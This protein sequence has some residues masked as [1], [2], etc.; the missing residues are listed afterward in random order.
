MREKVLSI[1]N[2]S[3]NKKLDPI[4]IISHMKK[5]YTSEDLKKLMECL[6]E[7]VNEGILISSKKN[8]FKLVT[9]EFLRAK[10][11][12]VQSG[13]GW[14]LMEGED[15]IFIDKKNML[16]A[17]TGDL[18]LL[19]TFR[20]KGEL[21]ARV[22]RIL[23]R[24]LPL[25]EV[26]VENSV[27]YLIPLKEYKLNIVLLENKEIPL[28]DGEIIRVKSVK[29]DRYN[30]YVKV[31]KKIGH[32]NSPDIDTLE[33]MEEL[34]VP[35][36][37]SE[38]ALREAQSLPTEVLESDF[39]GRKD[40]TNEMIFTIDGKDTKD[41][42]DAIGL[43]I[44]ENGNYLLNVSIADVTNYVKFGSALFND[45]YEK[46]NSTYMADRVEPMLPVELSNGICSLNEGV[47][48]CAVTTLIEL[49]KTGNVV[50]KEMF[51][52]IIKSKKK[53][54]YDDVNTILDG[55]NV[56]GYEE[57]K[58]TLLK[59]YELSCLVKNKMIERGE[60][61]FSSSEIKLIV[62]ENGKMTDIKKHVQYKGETLIEQFMIL[63]NEA[64]ISLLTDACDFGIFRVH[65]T[66]SPKKIEDFIKF[67]SSLGYQINAKFDYSNM[68]NKNIQ[69][70]LKVIKG[71][72]DEEILS[73]K[74]LRSMQKAIYST[75]NIGHY[76]LGSEKYTH[77]TSPIRRFSDLLL[78]YLIKIALF[79]M[80]M[81]VSLAQIG[82]GLEEACEHISMT[83]RRSDDAEYE[84]NDMKI[85]EYM[86]DHIGEEY[87]ARIVT[88]LKNGFFVETDKYIEGM[89]SLD[90]LKGYY[91]VSDD[92]TFYYDRKH[93]PCFK[94]GESVKVKCIGASKVRRQ[95]D[96][97]IVEGTYGNS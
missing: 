56:K 2:N 34:G 95:V 16:D 67:M 42:D 8:T 46:G 37:F 59:M 38:E 86:E 24:N 58:S 53:M 35:H 94:L 47:N 51:P 64:S 79:D 31:E 69:M 90:T 55:G 29:E 85:A 5:V 63:S 89:I 61:E 18:C 65:G 72:K 62:D 49:D 1:F 83:E 27:T 19:E 14:A 97:T 4:D 87:N 32:K 54:N 9:D 74:L 68:S 60:I 15:D 26:K 36:G 6:Y 76:G 40:L 81:G 50:R 23:E 78:H 43:K 93:K 73:D 20:N 11:E 82:S 57:F 96:F 22:K 70:I 77:E 48:R 45:A 13:N 52:S 30:I 44:L 92:M 71:T 17:C 41:I 21:E 75:T 3:K 84:V 88:I 12:R 80:D 39:V 33:V 28:V 66:P 91:T 25:C 10:V 7:L